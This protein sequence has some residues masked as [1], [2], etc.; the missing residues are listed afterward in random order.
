MISA[1]QKNTI[2]VILIIS[3]NSNKLS[4][5]NIIYIISFHYIVK[6]INQT[7]NT[8]IRK[9]MTDKGKPYMIEVYSSDNNLLNKYKFVI[10]AKTVSE[11]K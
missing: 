5:I 8:P 11:L 2:F 6:N 3:D 10:S 1:S 9:S 4:E 7:K